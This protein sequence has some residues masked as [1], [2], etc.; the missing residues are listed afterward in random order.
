MTNYVLKGFR[1]V[2]I[3]RKLM[4]FFMGRYGTVC[5]IDGLNWF[6]F[7]LSL[8]FIVIGGLC[9]TKIAL[10]IFNILS[11]VAFV[12]FVFRFFSKNIRA[13]QKENAFFTGFFKKIKGFF[14]LQKDR[15]R[16]RKT[17][18]YRKCPHCKIV[19]RLPRRKGKNAVVCP[20]CRER[21]FVSSNF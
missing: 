18:I 13:R 3:R 6:L 19:L 20:K 5:G 16:D 10:T 9:V 11:V 2:M 12:Y 1:F 15:F 4:R 21:F 14:K 8:A 17:H 7:A